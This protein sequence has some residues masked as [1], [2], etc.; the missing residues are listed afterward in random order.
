MND[1]D[2]HE[3]PIYKRIVIRVISGKENFYID[4]LKASINNYCERNNIKIEDLYLELS[5]PRYQYLKYKNGKRVEVEQPL[6]PG[7]IFANINTSKVNT[8]LSAIKTAKT[9]NILKTQ[10]GDLKFISE[11]D[12]HKMTSFNQDRK[13][14]I[15]S[16]IEIDSKVRIKTGSFA[17]FE[18]IVKK[19]KKDECS[20]EIM[21]F[22]KPTL[23]DI[24]ISG[25]EIE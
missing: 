2:T 25:L 6:N 23:V 8:F 1:L 19:I 22:G 7:Y 13:E 18:G 17:S 9:S 20:V 14:K 21:I 4:S 10:E 24:A 3:K 12:Y 5:C 16:K 15:T 11:E